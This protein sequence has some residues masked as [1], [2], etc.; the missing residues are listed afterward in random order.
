MKTNKQ[1]QTT[2]TQNDRSATRSPPNTMGRGVHSGGHTLFKL[3][4]IL[5]K[6][7]TILLIVMSGKN[8]FGNRKKTINVIWMKSRTEP[9]SSI[10]R[11]VGLFRDIE[12][13]D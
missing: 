2:E 10:I 7:S 9:N 1:K 8:I 6:T 4:V 5:D 13:W 12:P 11:S 3:L